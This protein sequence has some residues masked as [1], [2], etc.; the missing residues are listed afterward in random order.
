MG[1]TT[2]VRSLALLLGISIIA[3]EAGATPAQVLII[4]HAEKEQSG[5]DLSAR[6]Y[7]R[8]SK[9]VD[10][11][12]N[13]SRLIENGRPV[14]I[15]AGIGG[16]RRTVETVQPLADALGIAIDEDFGKQDIQAMVDEVLSAPAYSGKTVLVCWEHGEIPDIAAAFGATDAPSTWADSVFD[17]IWRLDFTPSG[18]VA[19][20]ANLPERLLPGDSST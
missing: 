6:G 9:L 14:A 18:Q 2:T 12:L 1:V 19:S 3:G 17:R 13:D 4:R 7:S 5:K 15:Y 16:S 10:L 20:F 8:A 11:F